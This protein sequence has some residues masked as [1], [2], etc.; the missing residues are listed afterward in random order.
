MPALAFSLAILARLGPLLAPALDLAIPALALAVD[1]REPKASPE[2]LEAVLAAGLLLAAE[3]VTPEE[4]DGVTCEAN[5]CEE[6][7]ATEVK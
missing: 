7:V 4:M 1:Q 6:P 2:G 5:D 3:G